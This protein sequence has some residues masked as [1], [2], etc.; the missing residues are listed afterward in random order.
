MIQSSKT[1]SC[2]P[3]SFSTNN[4]GVVPK[5]KIKGVILERFLQS[6]Y[7][8]S[9]DRK[10]LSDREMRG[11]QSRVV[12][13]L[14]DKRSYQVVSADRAPSE[15]DIFEWFVHGKHGCK[16]HR[17]S[18]ANSD[19]QVETFLRKA[20]VDINFQDEKTGDTPLILAS[21]VHNATLVKTL[22]DSGATINLVNKRGKAALHEAVHAIDRTPYRDESLFS[23]LECLVH[24]RA[25]VDQPLTYGSRKSI[26]DHAI[27]RTELR[28]ANL[29]IYSAKN[30]SIS[31]LFDLV[32]GGQADNPDIIRSLASATNFSF[33]PNVRG[34]NE[35]TALMT[36]S[37]YGRS[38]CLKALLELPQIDLEATVVRPVKTFNKNWSAYSFAA[39]Y[40]H[41]DCANLL[42][43]KGAKKIV[44]A[45][46]QHEQEWLDEWSDATANRNASLAFAPIA[47]FNPFAAIGMGWITGRLT[48]QVRNIEARRP[49]SRL[50]T[51]PQ[52]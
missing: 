17:R 40:G 46:T 10:A 52:E 22:V 42:V 21:R 36:A 19:L 50:D 29:F 51:P 1:P 33:D 39:S 4:P 15:S 9:R 6:Q 28:T 8:V 32:R 41:G 43:D 2:V 48:A 13:N 34:R 7:P 12:S 16:L 47:L 5:H 24:H 25:D 20:G 30:F 37:I 27:P 14:F 11:I 26:A 35:L 49:Q 3:F 18:V 23:T 38:G 45:L 44:P 31:V